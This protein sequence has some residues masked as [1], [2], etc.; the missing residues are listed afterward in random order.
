MSEAECLFLFSSVKN[1]IS[2][3]ERVIEEGSR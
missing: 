2:H 1:V 3:I